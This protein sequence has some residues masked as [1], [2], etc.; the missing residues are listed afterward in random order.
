MFSS[1]MYG[2]GGRMKRKSRRP[3]GALRLLVSL[4]WRKN[5]GALWRLPHGVDDVLHG[6][7]DDGRT[8]PRKLRHHQLPLETARLFAIS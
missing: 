2:G 1:L 8:S 7:Y 4:F 3:P 5:R 6:D